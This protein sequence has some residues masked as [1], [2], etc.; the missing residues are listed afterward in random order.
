MRKR[1]FRN[2]ISRRGAGLIAP[3]FRDWQSVSPT[4]LEP[5]HLTSQGTW[6]LA[7][8]LYRHGSTDGLPAAPAIANRA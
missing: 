8:L 2:I 7:N 5:G 6:S 1:A 3:Q 4:G